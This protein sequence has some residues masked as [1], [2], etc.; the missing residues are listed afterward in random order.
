MTDMKS[1]RSVAWLVLVLILAVG[2]GGTAFAKTIT[3]S[4]G[5]SI[6]AAINAAANG[7]VVVVAEGTYKERIDFKGKAITVRSTDPTNK[8]VV[9]ATIINGNKQGSVVTFDP[10]ETAACVL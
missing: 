3:V 9:K 4:P 6:Q 1:S 7:D 2:A 8:A 5:Q 10:D